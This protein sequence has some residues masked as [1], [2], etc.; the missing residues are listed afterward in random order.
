MWYSGGIM[1]RIVP[2]LAITALLSGCA[3]VAYQNAAPLPGE[4]LSTHQTLARFEGV[5]DVPCRHMTSLCP[6]RCDHGGKY[7]KFTIV[8]YT[9]YDLAGKYGDPKQTSFLVRVA[10]K[11]GSP[12]TATP[13]PLRRVIA[14]L[15][16]GQVVGLDWAHVY[17]TDPETGSK[18]PE[19]I[20]TKLAE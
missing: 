3:S 7:A 8:E 9:A 5:E 19:R 13:E 14:E 15:S 20:V 2:L 10:H 16:V 6:D 12:D 4:T 1:K 18:W 11:D 17:V